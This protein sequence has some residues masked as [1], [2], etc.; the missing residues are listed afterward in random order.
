MYSY[1]KSFFSTKTGDDSVMNS[2]SNINNKTSLSTSPIKQKSLSNNKKKQYSTAADGEPVTENTSLLGGSAGN[3][4]GQR[5]NTDANA[6]ENGTND[7]N[8]NIE[9]GDPVHPL[10]CSPPSAYDL[11]FNNSNPTVQRYYRFNATPITPIVALHKKPGA[12]SS[13]NSHSNAAVVTS[14]VT[15]LLRRSAVVPSHGTDVSGDWILVSVGGR[16]GWA[17]KKSPRQHFSGFTLAEKFSATEGWMGNHAF[18]C[19][20]KIMLGSDAPSLVFTNLLIVMG[21]VLH[22][23]IVLPR[24]QQME[25]SGRN[26][27]PG[28]VWLMTIFSSS[29]ANHD[30]NHG[31]HWH[32]Q[33]LFWSS[34][35]LGSLS[36]IMLWVSALMDPGIIPP[37]S[38]PAK[39]PV[40]DGVPLGGPL[41]YRYCSTCNIFRPPRS[42]HCNSCNVCVSKFDH[43][44]PWVGNC[45][46]ER[47]HRFF[48]VFLVCVSGMTILTTICALE[49]L[50]DAF[51][52]TSHVVT[53][54]DGT[55]INISNMQRLWKAILSE[56][57]TF[58]FGSFT[59]L[60][61][62][63]LTSLLCFH[64]M[65]ISVAQTTNERVRGVYRFGQVEN[66]A[67]KG[68][69]LNWYTAACTPC[70]V[71]RL[72]IDMSSQVITD[73]ATRP[74]MVWN[75][76][77]EEGGDT[78]SRSSDTAVKISEGTHLNGEEFS[79]AESK[80][81]SSSKKDS[82]SSPIRASTND[83]KTIITDKDEGLENGVDEPV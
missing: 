22:F 24:L 21:Y 10:P 4:L 43:H 81:T 6:N 67:D 31:W 11:Y 20:G 70:S 17:R 49:V 63:S 27:V 55:T 35:V 59:L 75:G 64:G 19:G 69:C 53:N 46:G 71:S 28:S 51:Q 44:C 82:T 77:Q 29:S 47:N 76:D 7:N 14:G 62:W 33:P 25:E 73:Y 72:P 42:K 18:A 61:A 8:V 68:C 48:F 78:V 66:K 57:L 60:C 26:L 41:G 15:G 13:N 9:N 5:T 12:S 83:E 40:P 38:S 74:E 52:T 54:D 16:S 2:D 56:K 3:E 79:I 58:L 80:N 32:V 34:V 65:I 23:C 37:V 45:I 1:L 50:L 39:A 36:L 30:G